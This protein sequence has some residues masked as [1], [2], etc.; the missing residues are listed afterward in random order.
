MLRRT[1]CNR[2]VE[3][4]RTAVAMA[5]IIEQQSAY[6]IDAAAS[7]GRSLLPCGEPSGADPQAVVVLEGFSRE[8]DPYTDLAGYES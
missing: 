7:K 3:P 6:Q 5:E 4:I 8:A 2:P 1:Q